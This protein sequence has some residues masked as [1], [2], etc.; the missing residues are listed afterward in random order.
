MWIK[1]DLNVPFKFLC[2]FSHSFSFFFFF[3]FP[4]FLFISD[5]YY[6]SQPSP[7]LLLTSFEALAP[8]FRM[9]LASN[10]SDLSLIYFGDLLFISFWRPLA[11]IL[12]KNSCSSVWRPLASLYWRPL[13][14][15]FG[16]LSLLSLET[17]RSSVLETSRSSFLGDLSL[18]FPGDLSLLS[19]GDLSLLFYWRPLAP[20]SFFLDLSLYYQHRFPSY[21][22]QVKIRETFTFF[23]NVSLKI[24]K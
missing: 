10:F 20:P 2:I 11:P 9:L 17:S 8:L 16:D 3:S 12:S 18:L 15:I 23:Y 1:I 6:F 13:A 22:T 7:I 21:A 5:S 19:F 4:A 14:P 24:T